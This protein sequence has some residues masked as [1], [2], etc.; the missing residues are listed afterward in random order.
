MTGVVISRKTRL[1]DK[2]QGI[3]ELEKKKRNYT[4]KDKVKLCFI[5][6]NSS[7]VA[8]STPFKPRKTLFQPQKNKKY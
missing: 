7:L 4:V 5:W 2:G 1:T 3:R 6:K 8:Q